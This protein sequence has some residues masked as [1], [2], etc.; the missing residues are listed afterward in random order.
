MKTSQFE[1]AHLCKAPVLTYNHHLCVQASGAEHWVI[2][3]QMFLSQLSTPACTAEVLCPSQ[4]Q[5]ILWN[6]NNPAVYSGVAPALGSSPLKAQIR[7]AFNEHKVASGC[8]GWVP[9]AGSATTKI[10]DSWVISKHK[11]TLDLSVPLVP[12]CYNYD[13]TQSMN[14]ETLETWNISS[15][16]GTPPDTTDAGDEAS[17]LITNALKGGFI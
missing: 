4:G 3:T 14:W 5:L 8:G 1:R 6:A 17:D 2:P 7:W 15:K 16:C 10:K 12:F 9:S 11:D 13:K